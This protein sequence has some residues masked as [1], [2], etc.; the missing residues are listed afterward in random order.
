MAYDPVHGQMVLFG[1]ENAGTFLNQTWTWSGGTWTQQ[2][3]ATVPAARHGAAM[4]WDPALNEIVMVGGIKG[5]NAAPVFIND[6]WAWTGSTW[7]SVTVTGTAPA[8]RAQAGFAWD[9]TL[10]GLALFGGATSNTTFQNDT[11]LLKNNAWTLIQ[12]GGS[13]GAPNYRNNAYMGYSDSTGQLVLFGGD[14]ATCS[15]CS[16]SYGSDTWVLGS[17]SWSRQSPTYSPS[18]RAEGEMVYDSGLGGLVLFGGYTG[19]SASP[20]EVTD[21]WAWNGSTWLQ[22]QGISTPPHSRLTPMA[23]TSSGQV[24]VAMSTSPVQTWVYDTNLPVLGISVSGGS[25]SGGTFYTGDAATV[26]ISAENAGTSAIT[27][28][29]ITSALTNLLQAAGSQLS[30]AGSLLS[31]C[32]NGTNACGVVANLIPTFNDLSVAVGAT[33][34]AQFLATVVGSTRGCSVIQV[35]G[36]A[37]NQWGGSA[38]VTA[39]M[40]V[41]GGGLGTEKW[42]TYD[43]TN[44]G[45]GASAN[46]NVANGNL[47]LKQTDTT[48][49]QSHGGLAFDLGRA[50]NSQDNMNTPGPLG[51]GWQWDLSST[52]DAASA[53]LDVGSLIVPTVQSVLQPLS[54]TYVDR[55][56]T[57]HVFALRGV[58][59]FVGPVGLVL[60][61]NLPYTVNSTQQNPL[62]L[63]VDASY[64]PPPG[65]DMYLWRYV[66]V[67]GSSC[68]GASS[69]GS[70]T[71]GWSIMRPDRLRYDYNL[72]GQLID[73]VDASGNAL[74][75]KY[76]GSGQV[77]QIFSNRCQS[78]GGSGVNGAAC[79]QYNI[80][81]STVTV[82]STTYN[83]VDVTDPAGRITTYLVAPAS[84]G[85]PA[86]LAQV[87]NP[88][89]PFTTATNAVPS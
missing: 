86:E 66:Q 63:C 2:S 89:D 22:A 8:G 70:Q 83:R 41:C 79:P 5:S 20:T 42:W 44:L 58:S 62:S 21:T 4:A 48:P 40:T 53:G 56:G 45:A 6:V 55:D 69:N 85:N 81:Y 52:G 31:S 26:Q 34:V 68:A 17:G 18:A 9:P 27:G 10:S 51:A 78:A 36:V 37:S 54:V 84:G 59:A 24:V 14:E 46:V 57:R 73:V 82:G 75:Y 71:L 30:W 65:V 29:T 11:W 33:S 15:T 72:Q 28:T 13:S 50:Y 19:T 88:D 77:T 60:G 7:S 49:I 76:N 32:P 74:D 12:A 67:N 16:T 3:P 25:G 87:W 61:G 39:P 1:G 47:V 80:A 64:S 43:S 35:P 38:S 23:A